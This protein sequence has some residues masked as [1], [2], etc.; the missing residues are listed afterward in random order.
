MNILNRLSFRGLAALACGVILGLSAGFGPSRALAIPSTISAHLLDLKPIPPQRLDHLP[1]EARK[2]Y[3]L[4]MK[5]VDKINYIKG[6][7]YFTHGVELS[8]DDVYLRFMVVQLAQ[9][10]G[11]TRLGE[12][13]DMYYDLALKHLKIIADSPR[14]NARE[15]ERARSALETIT[16]LRQSRTERDE[17]RQQI[18][19]VIAKK[20]EKESYKPTG[21]E[22]KELNRKKLRAQIK[23]AYGAK[24]KLPGSATKITTPPGNYSTGSANAGSAAPSSSNFSMKNPAN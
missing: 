22:K 11:D 15:K 1:P 20:Y 12:D 16:S 5:S 4:G 17:K 2:Q 24:N 8:P 10:L 6:L 21:K 3:D 19:M 13:S 23:A 18:G 7:E 14:L 9:Y